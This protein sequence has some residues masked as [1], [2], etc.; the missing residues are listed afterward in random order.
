MKSV[1]LLLTTAALLLSACTAA[2][3]QEPPPE[4]N[5]LPPL[6]SLAVEIP[7]DSQDTDILRQAA[8]TLP[9]LLQQALES[10]GVTVEEIRITVGSS[11]AATVQALAQ[12][13]VDL[14]FL[15]AADLA[16]QPEEV[17]VILLSGPDFQDG[18]TE[19]ENWSSG[20]GQTA[21]GHQGLLCTAPTEYGRNLA[22]RAGDLTWEELTRARW[23]VLREDSLLCRQAVD[24]WLTDHYEGNTLSDLPEVTVFADETALL[25]AAAKGEID[26][27]PMD[28]S[29][30]DRW[31]NL[32]TLSPDQADQWGDS[33][34]GRTAPLWDEV[35]VVGLTE[36]FYDMAAAV[37]PDSDTLSDPRF[38]QALAAAI[39]AL[40]V[41]AGADARQLAQSVFGISGYAP[42][43]DGALNAVRRLETLP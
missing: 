3:V 2:P 37:R 43:P 21:V 41:S 1:F 38:A 9:S 6:E 42:A 12:G 15:P 4:E 7:R 23:G 20:S 27:F 33:G 35:S 17:P 25:K 24:L 8:K 40:T 28:A 36:R 11:H 34:L 14:A 29:A 13:S 31:L 16:A 10:Q 19:L 18:G 5:D 39:E 32:W 26:L 30:R 22:G